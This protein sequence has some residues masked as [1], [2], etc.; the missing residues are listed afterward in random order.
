MRAQSNAQQPLQVLHSKCEAQARDF[1]TETVGLY[2]P[3]IMTA[4]YNAN[5]NSGPAHAAIQVQ[6]E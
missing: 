1:G 6:D 4:H 5:G 3:N 2:S